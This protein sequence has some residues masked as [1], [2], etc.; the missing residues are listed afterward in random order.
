MTNL[1]FCSQPLDARHEEI[2]Q[3][4]QNMFKGEEVEDFQLALNILDDVHIMRSRMF[5]YSSLTDKANSKGGRIPNYE[6]LITTM[7]VGIRS[8]KYYSDP[9][10]TKT[11][12]SITGKPLNEELTNLHQIAMQTRDADIRNVIRHRDFRSGFNNKSKIVILDEEKKKPL[13]VEKKYKLSRIIL[14]L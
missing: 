6:P 2:N 5:D 8:S 7:R 13:S 12:Q 10:E 9:Q 1:L 11:L 4:G 3:K 14:K